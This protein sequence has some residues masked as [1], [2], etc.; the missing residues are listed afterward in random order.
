MQALEAH[1][2]ELY[3]LVPRSLVI[4]IERAVRVNLNENIV[5]QG[6]RIKDKIIEGA[7]DLPLSS[8]QD[9]S[10]GMIQ[11]ETLDTHLY[12]HINNDKDHLEFT[13]SP[14]P[15]RHAA[16][17]GL[18]P[19]SSRKSSLNSIFLADFV[20]HIITE[21]KK[22]KLEEMVDILTEYLQEVRSLSYPEPPS[23]LAATG[24]EEPTT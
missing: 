17:H 19:Y 6:L 23:S 3:R 20:F 12:E 9:L 18:V 11:Y 24:V 8:L 16:V 15:N 13:E 5:G 2:K 14:I 7:D 21:M 22:E 1:E 10:S 4:E